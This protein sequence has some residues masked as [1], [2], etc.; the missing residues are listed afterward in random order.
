MNK[1]IIHVLSVL[2]PLSIISGFCYSLIVKI[3]P[4]LQLPYIL[5]L[6]M[7]LP[8]YSLAIVSIIKKENMIKKYINPKSITQKN[9]GFTIGLFVFWTALFVLFSVI[10]LYIF[11]TIFGTFIT[12]ND[13]LL[14]KVT[15]PNSNSSS[16]NINLPPSPLLLIPIGIFGVIISGLSINMIFAFFEEVLW[17]GYMWDNLA[18]VG[19]TKRVLIT[20]SVWGIWHAPL[21]LQGYNYGASTIFEGISGAVMFILFCTAFSFLF[22]EIMQKTKS[23]ILATG[24]HG[25]FNG[26]AGIFIILLTKNNPFVNGVIGIMSIICILIGVGSVRYISDQNLINH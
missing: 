5:L 8:I 15:D 2:F 1:N 24:M 7:P 11:P 20:G 16:Q 18:S 19:Y 3:A 22:E 6:Y 4:G 25:I 21:I 23:T 9:L 10:L 17:R 13:E 12:Q 14:K 26:F